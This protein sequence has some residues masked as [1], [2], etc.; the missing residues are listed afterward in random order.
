[1]RL[2]LEFRRIVS[3]SIFIGRHTFELSWV[4][5]YSSLRLG[6]HDHHMQDLLLEEFTVNRMVNVCY[7]EACALASFFFSHV[8][9]IN[10]KL[11]LFCRL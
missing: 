3:T 11:Q 5:L 6:M 4:S 8:I 9:D 10:Q 7:I 2:G 1:M